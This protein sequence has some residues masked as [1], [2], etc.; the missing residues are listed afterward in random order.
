MDNLTL[1]C[2]C[3]KDHENNYTQYNQKNLMLGAFDFTKEYRDSLVKRNFLFDDTGDNISHLN[4][5]FGDLT[6]TYWVWKNTSDEIVGTNHYR[7]FW[8]EYEMSQLKYDED[9]LYIVFPK[10]FDYSIY[11]Q[12]R[13]AHT[14]YGL[15][16]LQEAVK[17]GK[18]DMSQDIY[19]NLYTQQFLITCNMFWGHRKNFDK[20]CQVLFDILFEVYEGIK[21]VIPYIQPP[22][23]TR[24]MAFLAERI[25]TLIY[26]N[27]DYY[28]GNMK[29]TPVNYMWKVDTTKIPT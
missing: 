13:D 18:I 26:I 19:N 17:S 27:K 3:F 24:L 10:Y 20:M 6:G 9:T 21:Y 1:Y 16:V 11:E 25:C 29:L 8:N 15:W 7:K 14:A 28:L 23:Q 22:N 4:K 12:Y 5:W 2:N